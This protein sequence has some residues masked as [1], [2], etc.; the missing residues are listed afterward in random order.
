[1]YVSFFYD[2]TT[3][4]EA[5]YGKFYI[6]VPANTQTKFR[7]GKVTTHW[8]ITMLFSLYL[9]P[10]WACE[11]TKELAPAGGTPRRQAKQVEH[12]E[13]RIINNHLYQSQTMKNMIAE[14]QGW[15][16]LLEVIIHVS[17]K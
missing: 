8:Y 6:Q 10:L 2:C 13:I 9:A 5:K 11:P 15:M 1:M 16:A 4:H 14:R 7:W 17:L 12:I 3:D